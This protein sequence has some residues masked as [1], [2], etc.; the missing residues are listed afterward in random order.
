[1]DPLTALHNSHLDGLDAFL[2]GDPQLRALNR[3]PLACESPI[4]EKL[5]TATPGVY[6]RQLRPKDLKQV[7]KY[8]QA[9]MA[10]PTRGAHELDGVPV[11]PLPVVLCRLAAGRLPAPQPDEA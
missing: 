2:A 4:L 6:S 7:A 3:L 11:L 9:V 8:S 5:P 10:A 1:V